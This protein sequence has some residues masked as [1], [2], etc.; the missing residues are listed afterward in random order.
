MR[1]TCLVFL[2]LLLAIS[3][4]LAQKAK[5]RKSLTKVA[6]ISPATY[7]GRQIVVGSGGGFTGRTTM[8]YLLDTGDLFRK[9]PADT[10]FVRIGKQTAAT[11][12]RVFQ[13][14][15]DRCQIKKTK[16]YE[17][18]NVYQFVRWQQGKETY[19]VVWAP[20]DTAVPARYPN[21]YTA[22]LNMIP[23]ALR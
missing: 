16:F 15:E 17:P 5:P 14:V 10:T 6:Q 2:L 22:F 18:G 19:R 23:A 3:P 12:K 11:T 9:S 13:T 8:Y 20:G 7:E 21:V 1:H 4:L